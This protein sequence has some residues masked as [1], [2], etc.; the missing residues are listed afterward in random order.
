MNILAVKNLQM[1][2]NMKNKDEKMC[3]YLYTKLEKNFIIFNFSGLCYIFIEMMWR[4][5]SHYI[6]FFTGGL[7]FLILSKIYI[8]FNK[9]TFFKKYVIGAAVITFVEF[10]TGCIF[11]LF[12]GMSIW[13]Y[14]NL[15]L[16]ILGQV[17]LI[18]SLLWGIIG[19]FIDYIVNCKFKYK[20]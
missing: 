8:K 13:D 1:K 17:C 4:G 2:L 14:S 20:V 5:H 19:L 9:L 3:L 18:Y 10:F 15:P 6:M 12:F 16:N 11:N 7:C